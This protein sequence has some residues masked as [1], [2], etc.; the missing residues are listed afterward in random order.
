MS[1]FSVRCVDTEPSIQI[2]FVYAHNDGTPRT[3]NADRQKTE[4]TGT[5]LGR[6][7]QNI[8]KHINKKLR[9]RKSPDENNDPQGVTLKLYESDATTEV[10]SNLPLG[11]SLKHGRVVLIESE[12]YLVD[13]NPPSCT[14]ITIPQTAMV[15]FP[16]FPKLEVEF[17]NI[18]ESEYVWEKVKYEEGENSAKA[19]K[20]QPPKAVEKL[21]V[22][23]ALMYT[24]SNEDIGY[25][26][27]LTCVPRNGNR[28]GKA[29]GVES[30]YE[31]TAGPGFCP[32]ENRHL[33]T[34]KE[35]AHGE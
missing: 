17:C 22:G 30:K 19:Q 24:P 11:E 14:K 18:S 33:Y 15:G 35:T 16:I 4:D 26:L 9:K 8:N 20:P 32:F 7:A 3:F 28:Q 29:L 13:L 5:T 2:S 6:L 31:V 1:Q 12:K 34:Q 23:E 21:V 25:R 27:A 10:P